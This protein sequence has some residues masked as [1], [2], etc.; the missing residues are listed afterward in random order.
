MEPGVMDPR[1]GLRTRTLFLL[2]TADPGKAWIPLQNISQ[3]HG[4]W[5]LEPARLS[6]N[7]EYHRFRENGVNHR[8]W[9]RLDSPN[10]NCAQVPLWAA[11][12]Q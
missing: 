11:L 3:K 8:F 6:E 7:G 12:K 5:R 10:T 4:P 2:H 1:V 9:Q